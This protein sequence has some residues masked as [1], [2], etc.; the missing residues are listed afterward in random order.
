MGLDL[1]PAAAAAEINSFIAALRDYTRESS[2]SCNGA[3]VCFIGREWARFVLGHYK[4]GTLY[5]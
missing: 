4:K 5:T 2:D 1:S 3:C